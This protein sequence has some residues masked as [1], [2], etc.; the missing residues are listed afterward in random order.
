MDTGIHAISKFL[1]NDV[2]ARAKSMK[3]MS[4]LVNDLH[5]STFGSYTRPWSG[6]NGDIYNP[7]QNIRSFQ[8]I[9]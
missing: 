6:Y 2:R 1:E 3:S 8:S 7:T 9:H 4:L 5:S